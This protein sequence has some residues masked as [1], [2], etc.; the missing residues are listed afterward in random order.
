MTK[1]EAIKRIQDHMIIHKSYESRAIYITE[2]LE[3]AIK[4]LEES[5]KREE[6]NK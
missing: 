1:K 4:A 5:E 6:N 3:M 2:A